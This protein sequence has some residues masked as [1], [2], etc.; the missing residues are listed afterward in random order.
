MKCV[1]FDNE[2]LLNFWVLEYCIYATVTTH[3]MC[4]NTVH[5]VE[6]ELLGDGSLSSCQTLVS[7]ITPASNTW[8]AVGLYLLNNL[9]TDIMPHSYLYFQHQIKTKRGAQT[10]FLVV[11]SLSCLWLSTVPWTTVCQ[12]SLSFPVFTYTE[13]IHTKCQDFQHLIPDPRDALNFFPEIKG[14]RRDIDQRKMSS[15]CRGPRSGAKSGSTGHHLL[16]PFLCET[17]VM[18]QFLVERGQLRAVA[19]YYY[20][21]HFSAHPSIL[22]LSSA[23]SPPCCKMIPEFSVM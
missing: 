9:R 16:G 5:Y 2:P 22:A 1:L 17:Q 8:L 19:Q 18:G 11:Q 21:C 6:N 4:Y 15:N 3:I 13:W 12:A 23:S 7:P 20:R 14:T 10:H